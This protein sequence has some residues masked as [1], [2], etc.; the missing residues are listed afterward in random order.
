M[1]WFEVT[2]LVVVVLGS[3]SVFMSVYDGLQDAA[4]TACD[5]RCSDVYHT[6]RGILIEGHCVCVESS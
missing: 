3:V 1:R 4:L 2:M 5:E 6:Q